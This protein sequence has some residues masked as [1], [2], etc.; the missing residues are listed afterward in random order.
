[1][2]NKS[3][4]FQFYP[5]DWLSSPK[6]MM[7]TP[8]EEGAY[9]RLLAI[10]WA[11]DGLPDDDKRLAVLSRL[12]EDW[13][14]GS[15][16]KIRA[17]FTA[18][19][20]QLINERLA[21]E[22]KKQK[23]WSKKSSKGGTNSQKKRLKDV[24]KATR[25]QRLKAAREK[26]TH[27]DQE[28]LAIIEICGDKCVKCGASRKELYGEVLLRDH[29][30]PICIG[31]S[32]AIDNIQPMCRNCNAGKGIEDKD[33]RPNGWRQ[34]LTKLLTK[35]LTK[36][37]ING[38][39]ITNSSSS[40][41]TSS[42]TSNSKGTARASEPEIEQ[43]SPENETELQYTD[44]KFLEV[45]VIWQETSNISDLNVTQYARNQIYEAY[46]TH[47]AEVCKEC[48]GRIKSSRPGYI[49]NAINK[50]AANASDNQSTNRPR[51]ETD[52]QKQN[53]DDP[54]GWKT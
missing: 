54:F 14:E 24:P 47:G 31:G 36:S 1:M 20:G 52:T 12:G 43:I 8:A 30:K 37:P 46:L 29:I 23:E 53:P 18:K 32:D 17:C 49:T 40:S 6:I 28:W 2:S 10:C 27:T 9:I 16:D 48:F 26:G 41:S 13:S 39:P 7:M 35:L 25:A 38:Q 33:Y 34:S 22:R 4:A 50:E 42:S 21:A 5:N 44:P 19:D 51:T 15:G 45:I 11:N 3:P